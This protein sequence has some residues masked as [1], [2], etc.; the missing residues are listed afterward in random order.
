[1]FLGEVPQSVV[2]EMAVHVLTSMYAAGHFDGK[3]E[4]NKGTL[5]LRIT[6]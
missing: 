6:P 2:D 4:A 3:S 1:M 5:T